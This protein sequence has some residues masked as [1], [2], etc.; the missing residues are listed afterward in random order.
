MLQ[1]AETVD[2]D[3][4]VGGI[5][6]YLREVDIKTRRI[7]IRAL[8]A[9]LVLTRGTRPDQGFNLAHNLM[10]EIR[11]RF[12]GTWDKYAIFAMEMTNSAFGLGQNTPGLEEKAT[13]MLLRVFNEVPAPED[14]TLQIF[15][16]RELKAKSLEEIIWKSRARM[17]PALNG[18]VV[19]SILTLS[20]DFTM[21]PDEPVSTEQLIELVEKYCTEHGCSEIRRIVEAPFLSVLNDKVGDIAITNNS[22]GTGVILVSVWFPRG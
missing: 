17:L 8:L 16:S 22:D 19:N 4:I 6:G 13:E 14:E 5:E 3:N 12:P 18:L 10:A 15:L 20:E 7:F 11:D 2:L 9:V 21:T 1:Q